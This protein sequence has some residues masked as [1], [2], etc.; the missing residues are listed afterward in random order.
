MENVNKTDE[1]LRRFKE[2][3]EGLKQSFQEQMDTS[4]SEV[5]VVINKTPEV[6][7]FLESMMNRITEVEVQIE[8]QRKDREIL[9]GEIANL[10][11]N[12]GN[13]EEEGAQL[14]AEKGKLEEALNDLRTQV[15]QVKREIDAATSEKNEL[16][17]K[18]KGL[19]KNV[20]ETEQLQEN[21][22]KDKRETVVNAMQAVEKMQRE[23]P[24]L[25]FLLTGGSQDT[26]ELEIITTLVD[27][28]KAPVEEVKKNAKVPAAIAMRTV[29]KLQETG[30]IA[31]DPGSGEVRLLKEI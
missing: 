9:E 16:D 10:K 12:V 15:E 4:R 17:L 21:E 29:Q 11:T 23:E 19:E 13:S 30:L 25:D 7:H 1:L 2:S 31:Y 3:L 26:P 20:Q 22:L 8:R 6:G 24:I 18:V 5:E 27:E 28:G 14:D